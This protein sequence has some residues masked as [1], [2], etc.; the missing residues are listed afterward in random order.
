MERRRYRLDERAKQQEATRRRI[1]EATAELHAEVGPAATTI[2]AIAERAGVQRLTVYRHFPDEKGLFEACSALS[3]ERYPA[4]D[5][6]LWSEIEDPAARAEAALGALYEY[7]AGDAQGLALVLRDAEAL[8][9]LN[10]V[11][12]PF[13]EYLAWIA[14]DL[15]ARREAS[16]KGVR[17]IRAATGFA[18]DFWT[19][20]SLAAQGL[21]PRGSA[22][23]MA[24][25]IRVADA[26]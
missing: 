13:R 21:T 10:E 20:R 8:P 25:L 6:T 17:V 4:P 16:A 22:R 26:V 5:P 1:V 7:Y 11:L 18:V 23:L 19:F 24:A 15:A 9:A 2:S 3:D 14:D 12:A